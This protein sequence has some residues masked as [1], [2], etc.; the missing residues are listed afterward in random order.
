MKPLCLLL[1][2]LVLPSAG[3][4]AQA[5]SE[6]GVGEQ[7]LSVQTS[8]SSVVP[9][10]AGAFEFSAV[11]SS[12][13]ALI[14]PTGG[15]S[16]FD[17]VAADDDYEVNQYFATKALMTAAF[18]DGIYEIVPSGGAPV[19][20]TLSGDLYPPVPQLTNGTWSAGGVLLIDPT[21]PYTF[22]LS[23]FPNYLTAGLG[24]QVEF[25]ILSPAGAEVVDG[26][27]QSTSIPIPITSFPILASVLTPGVTYTGEISFGTNV[28]VQQ[29]SGGEGL[30][31]SYGSSTTFT[32]L[33]EAPAT[34][35]PT[36]TTQPRSVTVAPGSTTV[37]SLGVTSPTSASFQWSLNGLPIAGATQSSLVIHD[38]AAAA[39]GS[40]TCT[41]TN[42]LGTVQSLPASLALSSAG[43]P[44]RLVNIS[45]R[46][47][48]GTGQDILIAGFAVG[49]A[50]T[51]GSLPV[52]VRGSGPALAS[53]GVA[54]TLPD[55][56]LQLF[57]GASVLA[58]NDGWGTNA[59][60]V[61]AADALV[62][63]FPFS[64][65]STHDTALVE[66]LAGGSYTAQVSGES[67]D[68]GVALAEVYDATPAG[69]YTQASPRIVNL[70][71]RVV[72]GTGDY[73]AIAGFVL[74]GSTARTVL[75]RA[76]GPALSVFG[77]S[78]VLA[79]PQLQLLSA[80]SAVLAQNVGWASN[81]QIAS[82]AASVGAFAWKAGG[83][84]SAVLATL[85]PGAYTAE[86]SGA[87]GDVGVALIEIYEVP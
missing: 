75:I 35:A 79:D 85:P 62:G 73:I 51:A 16:S 17:P 39:V 26:F 28:V 3:L 82:A 43:L 25:S 7:S 1:G 24:S 49:G 27:F 87:T 48:V 66:A 20:V 44:G 29:T 13:G 63:A 11:C 45:C 47:Q 30:L 52:L 60:A 31:A 74:S 14:A 37:F 23:S 42:T 18:P 81:P 46:A 21:Q 65:A 76:S 54:G 9:N 70:S 59:A 34:A 68:T 61:E 84:D 53:Y 10:P 12:P 32:I 78:G 67:G 40:Y 72:V 55:P 4:R 57:Q 8:A 22:N 50:G 56:A 19:D 36:I 33:A 80:T 41:A 58:T 69:A 86:V 83:L 6:Y 5:G 64:S 77:V 71:A 2:A 15:A 38:P